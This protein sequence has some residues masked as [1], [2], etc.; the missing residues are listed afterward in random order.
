MPD[1]VLDTNV[2]ADFLA[3]FFDPGAA[4]RGHGR[5]C[6]QDSITRSLARRLNRILDANYPPW[7]QEDQTEDHVPSLVIASGFAFIEIARK[8]RDTVRD[9]F[10]VDR[11]YAFIREP[12]E[13]FDIAPVDEDLLPAYVHV[14]ASIFTQAREESIE[15]PDALHVAT[16][17]SR[18]DTALLATTDRRLRHMAMLRDR[19]AL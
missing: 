10:G 15:L 3:Q 7:W 14:P 2:L 18:G 6:V 11:F 5:F 17:L 4:E 12:P 8:W 16:V 9:R 13:W 1:I 19:L